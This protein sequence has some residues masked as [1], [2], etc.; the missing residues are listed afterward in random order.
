[1][2][3]NQYKYPYAPMPRMGYNPPPNHCITRSSCIT[4][5]D[6]R[7]LDDVYELCKKYYSEIPYRDSTR[8][9]L[10]NPRNVSA[11]SL[12]HVSTVPKSLL[13]D[14]HEATFHGTV[15]EEEVNG[16]CIVGPVDVPCLTPNYIRTQIKLLAFDFSITEQTLAHLIYETISQYSI[17]KIYT[18]VPTK[19][20]VSFWLSPSQTHLFKIVY[21]HINLFFQESYAGIRLPDVGYMVDDNANVF[22]PI[23]SPEKEKYPKAALLKLRRNLN[24]VQYQQLAKHTLVFPRIPA[25]AN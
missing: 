2:T 14:S 15:T 11:I 22:S 3:N 5:A 7:D 24:N 23:P 20:E 16:V 13:T 25:P 4:A 18:E 19:L 12:H 9:L 8:H 10:R 6:E 21:A 17:S 1:M